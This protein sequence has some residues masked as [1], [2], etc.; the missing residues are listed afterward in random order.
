MF[1]GEGSAGLPSD[2]HT[3]N[4]V[5]RVQGEMHCSVGGSERREGAGPA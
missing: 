3:G 1:W 4:C 2:G 5:K